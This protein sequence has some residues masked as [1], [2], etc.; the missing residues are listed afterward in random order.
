MFSSIILTFVWLEVYKKPEITIGIDWSVTFGSS[1]IIGPKIPSIR[2]LDM[3][4]WYQW[5][6]AFSASQE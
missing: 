1:M 6:P 5:V 2:W 3:W 4:L